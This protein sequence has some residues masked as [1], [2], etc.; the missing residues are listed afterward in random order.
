MTGTRWTAAQ[1]E[2]H[3]NKLQQTKTKTSSAHSSNAVALGAIKAKGRVSDCNEKMNGLER[4]Y[5]AILESRRQ[6]GE[7]AMWMYDAI[8]L[9]LA[10]STFYHP[11][12]LVMLP[13]GTLQIHETKGFMRDDAAVKLKTAAA[14][15]PFLSF[16]LVTKP[17]GG[18]WSITE[19]K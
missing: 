17:R 11:D 3:R 16:F 13:D 6:S 8:S 10:R 19:I 7:I 14:I 2:A 12:F 18:G 9:R 4:D 15:F 1:L 5:A